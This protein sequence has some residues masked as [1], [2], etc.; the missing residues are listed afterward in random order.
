MEEVKTSAAQ[1]ASRFLSHRG[2]DV[3][4][5][6]WK[7]EAGTADIVARDGDALVFARVSVRPGGFPAE[8][9]GALDR[10]GRERV[11]LAYLA[12][13]DV[14]D[15]PIRFDDID[16]A[17]VGTDRAMIRHHI[18]SMCADIPQRTLTEAA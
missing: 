11:A 16:M 3:L 10:W 14:A 6:G 2:Y 5:T 17:I 1:A 4:E 15:A 7:S 8:G 13:H 9:R 12:E 18:N